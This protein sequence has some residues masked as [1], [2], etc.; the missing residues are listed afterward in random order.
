MKSWAKIKKES[1]YQFAKNWAAIKPPWKPSPERVNL[2]SQLIKKY[3]KGDRALILGATPEVRDLL[4]KLKF[5]VTLLDISPEMV[6]ATTFL[7]KTK[8]KE[9]IVI[10]NWLTKDLKQKYD[11]I[12]GDSVINN[13]K[14]KD[15][16]RFLKRMRRLLKDNGIFICQMGILVKPISKIN[17][18]LKKI[19]NKAK[20]RPDY[21]QNYVNRA[22]DYW[23]CLML[24]RHHSLVDW[25]YLNEIYRQKLKKGEISKKEFEL[26]DFGLSNLVASIPSEK[27]FILLLKKFWQI[28]DQDYERSHRVYKDFYRIYVLKPR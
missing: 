20:Y 5:K 7:R 23:Q 26:L 19:I 8:S 25:G 18:S 4:A 16:P 1:W 17:I 15:H 9:K 24:R 27:D 6:K 10:G 13:L 21:Y 14:P 3:V 22:Y 12:I 2:Y 11:L 28:I